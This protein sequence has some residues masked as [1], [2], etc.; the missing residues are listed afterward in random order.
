[1]SRVD[2]TTLDTVS[3]PRENVRVKSTGVTHSVAPP[4]TGPWDVAV[5]GEEFL[6]DA[7]L[8]HV[9]E[10]LVDCMACVTIDFED[11]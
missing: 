2:H 3:S 7:S 8:V 1:M 10:G 5:C 11:A 9:T 4:F 6:R